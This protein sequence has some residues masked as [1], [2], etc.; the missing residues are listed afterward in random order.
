MICGTA[1]VPSDVTIVI[2]DEARMQ[3]I[4]TGLS[5]S[6]RAIW[7]PETRLSV[8]LESIQLHHPK[9]IA[10]EAAFAETVQGQT[11]IERVEALNIRATAIQLIIRSD[12][13]W[14][15]TPRANHFSDKPG[16]PALALVV[17]TLVPPASA[18]TR[19]TPRFPI[20]DSLS[21]AVEGGPAILVNIS[22]MGAQ[23]TSGSRLRP[24]QTVK[25]G[26]PQ[27]GEVLHLT[28]SV[29]W[30]MLEQGPKPGEAYYRAGM[31]FTDDATGVLQEYC[32]SLGP[33]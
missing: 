6:G 15:T 13:R 14:R 17:P 29:A 2:A 27:S 7:F 19:R 24:S 12:G 4:R 22:A 5:L 11:F 32:R 26:F 23:V 3:A 21:V 9:L 18:N 8:A 16:R 28:A 33:A 10:I 25:F 31:E 20:H 30:S 1:F